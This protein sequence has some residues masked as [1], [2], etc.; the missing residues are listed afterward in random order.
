MAIMAG[1]LAIAAAS[2]TAAPDSS[3][4]NPGYLPILMPKGC[5][6]KDARVLLW[7][8][9]VDSAQCVDTQALLKMLLPGC[10]AG[11]H[12]VYDG[13]TFGCADPFKAAGGRE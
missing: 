12:V 6:D 4:K 10:K 9:A 2:A 8:D 3:P 7:K 13:K 5:S 1:A 11:Q